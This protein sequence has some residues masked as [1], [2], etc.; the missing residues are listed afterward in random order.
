MALR[1][2]P[3]SLMCTALPDPAPS[4]A[5]ELIDLWVARDPDVVGVG[6][7]PATARA[8]AAAWARRTGG[9]SRL[10]V[11]MAMHVATRDRGPAA[12]GRRAAAAAPSPAERDQV[13]AAGGAAFYAEAEP[14]HPDDAERDVAARYDG[15]RSLYVWEDERRAR[16]AD[17]R[18]ADRQRLRLDR[19]R[20]H[21][22][23]AAAAAATRPPASPPTSRR[24]LDAGA[25]RCLLFTDLDNPTSNKIYREVGYRRFADWE[26]HRF[27]LAALTGG[28]WPQVARPERR[29]IDVPHVRVRSPRSGQILTPGSDPHVRVRS[30]RPGQIPTSGSDPRYRYVAF[31]RDAD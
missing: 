27:T 1:T 11:S 31:E 7:E 29:V 9:E 22:A 12:A 20:L 4:L 17:L 6:A 10:N 28:R 15:D 26:H 25:S 19:A 24:L 23:R 16:V 18:A 5:A 13:V 8:I 2:P 14:L 21:A 30:P 3:Q